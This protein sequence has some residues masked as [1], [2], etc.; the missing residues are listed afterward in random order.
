M[1]LLMVQIICILILVLSGLNECSDTTSC[2]SPSYNKY[3]GEFNHLE[4]NEQFACET[5]FSLYVKETIKD[6]DN[7]IKYLAEINKTFQKIKVGMCKIN[8]TTCIQKYKKISVL[9]T[10]T[11]TNLN[12]GDS[13]PADLIYDNAQVYSHCQPIG[14]KF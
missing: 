5:K 3:L 1:V 14:M 2:L 7:K 12:A 9:V 10:N 6:T 13:I 4:G 8:Q 11:K